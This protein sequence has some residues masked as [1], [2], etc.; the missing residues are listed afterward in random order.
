MLCR[1]DDGAAEQIDEHD[2]DAGDGI[3]AN[4][5][6]GTVH[7]AVEVAFLANFLPADD[8]FGLRDDS[9]VQIGVDR[10]LP[11][12]HRVQ[13]EARTD[14]RDASGTLGDHDEIDDHQH[15]EHHHAHGIV[16]ADDE[17]AEGGNHMARGLRA[18]MSVD[19]HD[20]G[21]GDVQPQAQ[22]RGSEQHGWK[23]RE[24]ERPP[25]VDHRQQ[26]HQRQ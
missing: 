22:Q 15:R 25:H 17:V 26:D 1:A 19:E 16:A 21:R 6:A 9:R 4:E 12:G 11:A 3:A 8:G 23:G 2:Q 18:G 5:L 13:G 7:R 24:L 20:A 10:H 14:F